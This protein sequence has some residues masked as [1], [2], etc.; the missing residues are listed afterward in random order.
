MSLLPSG[1]SERLL[2]IRAMSNAHR[3][4]KLGA[5][6]PPPGHHIAAWRH[7]EGRADGGLDFAH[8]LQL[9]QTAER[10]CF[11]FIFLSDG[12]GI[13]T[14]YRSE[15]ELS[16]WGRIV[17]FEP[18]T[19][20]SAL[21]AVTRNI[22]LTATA[23]TTY[24][25][26]FHIARKFASLDFLSGG[27]AGWNIV[28]SVTDVEAQNFNLDRQ[29]D[30]A[31]R[32]RRAREFMQVVTG[33]W[34]SWE[35]DAFLYDKETGRYFDPSKLHIL[36]HKCEFFSVRGPLNV[37]R[38]P[39]GYPVLVQAGASD[40]GQDFA[41][42]WA[43]VVFTAQQTLPQAKAF[44]A[45]LKE[46]MAAYG[47]APEQSVLMPGVFPVVA[48]TQT[49]AEDIYKSLQDLIDPVV[50]LGLLETQLGNVDI[51]KFPLDEPLPVLPKTEG[52]QSKQRL[53]WEQA[54]RKGLTLRQLAK[55]VAAGRGH[56]LVVGSPHTIADAL[57]DWF[58]NDAADGF[59]IMPPYLPGQLTAF[60]DLVIPEL[61]RRGIFRSS[62][63]GPTLRGN[64]G[65]PRPAH[66]RLRSHR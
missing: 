62:Y 26:P 64:L 28:T 45:S 20:L 36:S 14:H 7:P 16:H 15:E 34:D 59:N 24:N 31:T 52:S 57:E 12:L 58:I 42:Q 4:M 48:R 5:F 19:L 22:G 30:H 41:A 35:D 55:E 56:R 43:E 25:E 11:D 29:P 47:R 17:N 49:E 61:Q 10:G 3:W 46:Q 50:S 60:V 21:S 18:I 1:H 23:S 44:Y 53:I 13:R 8:Y 63:D 51:T 38:P 39:Q 65:L 32:Y 37:A 27:R 54:Q 2:G 40:D 6:L 33:L 66:P 9:G